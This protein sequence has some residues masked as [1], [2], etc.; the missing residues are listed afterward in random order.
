MVVCPKC[1]VDNLEGTR[2][3]EMCGGVLVSGMRHCVSC[4]RSIGWDA[5]VCPY[6]GHDFRMASQSVV[7]KTMST[8]IKVLLYLVSFLIPV[9]GIIIGII[10]MTR[11]DPEEKQ[12]GKICLILGI[13]SILLSVGLAAVLYVMVLG[14]GTDG[15]QTPTA[16]L[17]KTAVDGGWRF[18]FGPITHDVSWSDVQMLL[19]DGT[20]A[21]TWIPSTSDLTG[22]LGVT[23]VY[24]EEELSGILVTLQVTDLGGNGRVNSGDYFTLTAL[25]G[26]SPAHAYELRVMYRPTDQPMASTVFSG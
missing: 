24:S 23:E 1:G 4:G 8:G 25:P 21:V 9:A 7:R 12:V 6:C 20:D 5:N 14:F 18:T 11:P 15:Y 26:F 17:S 3:C 16:V 13:L 2:T 19:I 10:F 22:A